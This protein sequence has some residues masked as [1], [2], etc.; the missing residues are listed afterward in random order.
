M[1]GPDIGQPRL[2]EPPPREFLTLADR[3]GVPPFSVLDAR[4]GYW[5]KRK[6][7]WL[8]LGIESEEGR[9]GNLIGYSETA[10]ISLAGGR[11]GPSGRGANLL[12]KGEL[13]EGFGDGWDVEKGESAWGGSGTSIFDPVLCELA[14][15]WFCP[16][17]GQVLDPFAGGAVR[18]ITA[19]ALGRHYLGV[20]LSARQV[21]SNEAQYERVGKEFPLPGSAA[22]A[23]GDSRDL[24]QF[25]A[26]RKYDFCFSCPPYYDLEQYSDDPRDL[27]N[28][29]TYREFWDGYFACIRQAADALR[30]DRFALFVVG[31]VRD[32]QGFYCGL[33][34]DTTTAWAGSGCRLYNEAILVT[35][36]GSLPIRTGRNFPPFRKLG[37]TH[38]N[39]LTFCK[40]SPQKAA[41]ACGPVEVVDG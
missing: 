26:G 39:V 4:S 30:L 23:V 31:E 11:L 3:F 28:A 7:E 9:D 18:G 17:G 1:S 32:K 40:G 38:Q 16:P 25:T 41:Q 27:S 6:Q 15:R 22:W 13:R 24:G 21:E 12:H 10:S 8:S 29:P 35:S 14:Y 36:V 5:Q 34:P 20:D 33:V 37:K 2:F 19:A